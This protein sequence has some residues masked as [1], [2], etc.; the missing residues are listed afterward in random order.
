MLPNLTKVV[1]NGIIWPNRKIVNV[2]YLG[3]NNVTIDTYVSPEECELLLFF[4][5]HKE[6][7]PKSKLDELKKL[8]EAYSDAKYNEGYEAAEIDN[9][10]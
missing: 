8:I 1:S 7:I 10:D 5:S 2:Q 9:N 4:K 3:R 6:G